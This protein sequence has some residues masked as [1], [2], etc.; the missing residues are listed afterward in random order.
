MN[1]A[2]AGWL[3]PHKEGA[4]VLAAHNLYAAGANLYVCAAIQY[5]PAVAPAPHP[6]RYAVVRRH[7]MG[8]RKWDKGI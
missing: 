2:P 5:S 1:A 4:A 6:I 3:A 7:N 8:K